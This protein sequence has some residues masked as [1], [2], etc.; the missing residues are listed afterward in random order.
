MAI[1][2]PL[3]KSEDHMCPRSYGPRNIYPEKRGKKVYGQLKAVDLG[4][5]GYDDSHSSG[6]K[7]RLYVLHKIPLGITW[8]EKAET[9]GRYFV[10]SLFFSISSTS[11]QD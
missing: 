2:V 3:P 11:W 7:G 5:E 9:E 10:S 8:D 1:S 6:V 4:I